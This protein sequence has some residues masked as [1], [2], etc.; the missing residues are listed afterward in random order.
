LTTAREFRHLRSSPKD[1]ETLPQL[2]DENKD[3]E[4]IVQF[5][6]WTE[7]VE[8]RADLFCHPFD[9]TMLEWF[10]HKRLSFVSKDKSFWRSYGIRTSIAVAILNY[11]SQLR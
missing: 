11:G 4:L 3:R 7:K 2:L 5:I 9:T 8:E 1:A 6:R 10:W